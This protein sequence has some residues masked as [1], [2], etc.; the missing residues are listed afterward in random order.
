MKKRKIYLI[1]GLFLVNLTFP[2]LFNNSILP[3]RRTKGEIFSILTTIDTMLK[4]ENLNS[5]DA[6]ILQLAKRLLQL[7]YTYLRFKGMGYLLTH[8]SGN[9]QHNYGLR[10][11]ILEKILQ[12]G[13]PNSWSYTDIVIA[14]IL[15]ELEFLNA[16]EERQKVYEKLFSYLHTGWGN[17]TIAATEAIISRL[18]KDKN[19]TI[20]SLLEVKLYVERIST[21]G[22]P[23]TIARISPKK[24]R[25]LL[26]LGI[27]NRMRKKLTKGIKHLLSID[28]LS[29][30]KE[31][32]LRK[33]K[34]DITD[35]DVRNFG[36]LLL[37]A[38]ALD[39][40]SPKK[41]KLY[42][43]DMLK[44]SREHR[45]AVQNEQW[46][47]VNYEEENLNILVEIS[48]LEK[49]LIEYIE[50]KSKVLDNQLLNLAFELETDLE[51]NKAI[52]LKLF[53]DNPY[54]QIKMPVL[55]GLV[56]LGIKISGLYD[57]LKCLCLVNLPPLA[58][59]EEAH[60]I[61]ATKQ[62]SGDF[63]FYI[64]EERRR[65]DYRYAHYPEAFSLLVQLVKNNNAPEELRG[66]FTYFVTGFFND[67]LKPLYGS[68]EMGWPGFE[69]HVLPTI[70]EYSAEGIMEYLSSP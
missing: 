68:D 55:K 47:F 19:N 51:L 12:Y 46:R 32:W 69:T 24:F 23:G 16:E 56:R 57:E 6:Q 61:L 33:G 18:A 3:F 29:E 39:C 11:Q 40:L 43:E 9:L 10:E 7:P 63:I 28:N 65:E 14:R 38:L 42:I 15:G 36:R 58:G 48:L 64:E 34:E 1:V 27:P 50:E 8:L 5:K 13:Q 30:A 37:N 31:L 52:L 54:V 49:K 45:E 2:R 20:L 44:C 22:D 21:E 41:V 25:T 62:K 26:E 17:L 35:W 67:E 53:K 4:N 60:H 59:L 66:F 70:I